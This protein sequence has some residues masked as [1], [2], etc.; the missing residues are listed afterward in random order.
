MSAVYDENTI[1]IIGNK[2]AFFRLQLFI[3]LEGLILQN[4]LVVTCFLYKL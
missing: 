4:M 2:L 3:I 1:F